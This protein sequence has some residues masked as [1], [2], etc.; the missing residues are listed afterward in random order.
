VQ[1]INGFR[2]N[3]RRTA[4]P[5]P[6]LFGLLG[7][8]KGSERQRGAR[9]IAVVAQAV[10]YPGRTGRFHP[11]PMGAFDFPACIAGACNNRRI[12]DVA[13]K[14]SLTDR[15]NPSHEPPPK[16]PPI[17]G[18]TDAGAL[19]SEETDPSVSHG[20]VF[21]FE[22]RGAA[23]ARRRRLH[24]DAWTRALF[25]CLSSVGFLRCL[26]GTCLPI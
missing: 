16:S 26:D 17:L 2:K 14:Q 8:K 4:S 11:R 7:V 6:S 21:R 13:A 20:P 22:D 18:S 3:I 19:S 1:R 10:R 12:T 25:D 15:T 23:V 9:A 24:V 5:F